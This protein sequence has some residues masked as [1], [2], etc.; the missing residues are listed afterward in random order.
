MVQQEMKC[1]TCGG[2]KFKHKGG[3]TYR[4]AYCGGT[5]IGPEPPKAPESS[6]YSFLGQDSQPSQQAEVRPDYKDKVTALVLCFFFGWVG[7]HK[8]YLRQTGWGV[9][10][11]IFCWTQIPA[12]VA[13]IEFIIMACE[14]KADFDRKYNS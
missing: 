12:I 2:D 4:C 14:S 8:F 1:P 9:A 5:V 11:L 7:A 13:F 10:Y 3:V 6:P